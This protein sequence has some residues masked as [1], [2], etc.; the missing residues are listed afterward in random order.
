MP[1]S[2]HSDAVERITRLAGSHAA[3]PVRFAVVGAVTF[4]LQILLLTLLTNLGVGSLI[5]YVVALVI[6]AVR[7]AL[8]EA[9]AFGTVFNIVWVVFDLVIF[10]V[11]IRAVRYRGFE[12]QPDPDHSRPSQQGSEQ[13]AA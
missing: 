8:G 5:A 13:G 1:A 3:R 6:G 11:I 7:L 9:S 10:S 4:G 2:A 12:A